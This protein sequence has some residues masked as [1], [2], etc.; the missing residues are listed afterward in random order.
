MLLS[1][2]HGC[3]IL[4]ETLALYNFNNN[5]SNERL[6]SLI[7]QIEIKPIIA[8]LIVNDP[9]SIA[10][11]VEITITFFAK[12][13]DEPEYFFLCRLLDYYLALY[14]PVN[15]FSRIVTRIDSIEGAERQWP[16]RAGRLAW[17]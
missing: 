17:F 4:K 6:I 14:A 2:P 10:R 8:R 3:Q 7:S 1:G 16:I 11:G 13:A 12:A 9:S 5:P 15:S